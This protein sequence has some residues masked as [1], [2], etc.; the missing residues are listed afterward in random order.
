MIDQIAYVLYAAA[1]W[2]WWLPSV[3]L[4]LLFVWLLSRLPRKVQLLNLVAGLAA[5][6][7][8]SQSARL[9]GAVI[10]GLGRSGSATL[11]RLRSSPPDQYDIVIQGE[12]GSVH[13]VMFD[14]HHNDTHWDPLSPYTMLAF[15]VG[16]QF[17]VR[18]LGASPEHF[19]II[20]HDNSPWAHRVDCINL[21]TKI[22][23]ENDAYQHDI[24]YSA[25]AS[26]TA[27]DKSIYDRD[28]HLYQACKSLSTNGGT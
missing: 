21:A 24:A 7:V 19:V 15:E 26:T 11:I 12:D 17:N 10:A 1:N 18:Y 9:P 23:A 27:A 2:G 14:L 25:P 28:Q 8:F 22:R 13:P 16:D 3:L 6:A 4:F 5:L 20:L